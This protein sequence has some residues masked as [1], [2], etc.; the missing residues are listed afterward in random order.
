MLYIIY[1]S[2]IVNNNKL[3]IEYD[4]V[5]YLLRPILALVTKTFKDDVIVTIYTLLS[6]SALAYFK[7]YMI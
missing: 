4:V 2:W 6:R 5:S 7:Y 3:L 1:L